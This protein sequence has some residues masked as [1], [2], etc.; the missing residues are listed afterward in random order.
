MKNLVIA[1]AVVITAQLS[2]QTHQI[3]KHNGEKL[4]VNFI[5]LENNLIYYSLPSRY[6]EQKISKYAVAELNEKSKTNHNVISEKIHA[7]DKSEFKKVLVLKESETVGLK[8]VDTLNSF[9]GMIKNQSR[10][11]LLKLGERQLKE[12]AA[13]KGNPFIVIISKTANKLKAVSYTY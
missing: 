5:K 3:I 4:D 13:L 7:T 11:P 9:L 6:E 1:I 2:A 8:K 12:K 10:L